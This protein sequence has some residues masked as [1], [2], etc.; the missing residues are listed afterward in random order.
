MTIMTIVSRLVL[1][2][3]RTSS[4]QFGNVR[5]RFST[6][7]YTLPSASSSAL[8]LHAR[9]TTQIPIYKAFSEWILAVSFCYGVFAF[10]YILG[11]NI[12]YGR[13]LTSITSNGSHSVD[14]ITFGLIKSIA[15]S[16]FSFFYCYYIKKVEDRTETIGNSIVYKNH[17]MLPLIP[18][19]R[20]YL[21]FACEALANN[22]QSPYL[23][24]FKRYH[25]V[26]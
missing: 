16:P 1:W 10:P 21:G 23:D 20:K 9:T 12:Y 17:Y 18:N 2:S 13:E 15:I 25:V 4:G 11:S 14:G 24:F 5:N 26:V 8:P 22:S 19:S 7:S 3:T 6:L